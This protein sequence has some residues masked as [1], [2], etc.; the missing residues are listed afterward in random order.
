MLYVN[1]M[2]SKAHLI[3]D[4]KA[5]IEEAHHIH[6]FQIIVCS[7]IL[8]QS[9]GSCETITCALHSE[10]DYQAISTSIFSSAKWLP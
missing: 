1:R 3:T 7:S 5:D 9:T 2:H 4:V 8:A 10:K 6:P